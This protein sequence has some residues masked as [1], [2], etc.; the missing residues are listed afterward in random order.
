MYLPIRN[1]FWK[2]QKLDETKKIE[3]TS[4]MNKN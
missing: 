4:E 2:E 1:V 3:I